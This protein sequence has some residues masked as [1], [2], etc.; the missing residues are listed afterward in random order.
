[1]NTSL[2]KPPD[3]P[4]LLAVQDP[5]ALADYLQ[6][7][8][9]QINDAVGTSTGGLAL[10]RAHSDLVDRVIRRMLAL[11]CERAG[12]GVAAE[13]VPIAVVATGGYGRRELC[14]HSDI[15]ITFIPHRDGDP[16]VDRVIKEM[17]TLVMR[18]FIDACGM[19]VG[20]A[21]RLLAD[22]G[23]LDHQTTC[24]LLD[25]R[26]IAGSDRLFIQ[27][28]N[29]FWAMLNPAD[30]LFAKL[31]ER[32]T[33][34]AKAGATP[35][36]VE[37]DLK[38]GAGGLR[39]LQTAVWVTQ[40]RHGLSA[41]RVRGD[42]V[43]DVLVKEAGVSPEE[44]DRLRQAKEFLFRVRS[45]LHVL[46]GAERDQLV[47]TRQE[48]LADLL[49][50]GGTARGADGATPPVEQFMREYY[51]HAAAVARITTDVMRR[52][53]NSRLFLGIGLDCKRRQIVPANPA[54]ACEDPLWMLWACELAQ[55]Y[56]LE[57]SDDLE[58]MIVDLVETRPV[59][60]D[61]EQAAE[62][63]TRILA[64][65]HGAYPT[66]QRMAD[67][68]ILGWLVPEVGEILNLIPYDPSH[69]Y[70]VGQH[71]LYVIRNLDA[72]RAADLGE[73]M[74]DFRQ[75]MAELPHPEQ[76]YLAALLHDAGKTT[77]ERPHSEVGEELAAEVCARLRWGAHAAANVQFL[78]RHHLTMAET[79]RLRDLNLDE[80]IRD[81]TSVVDDVD[82]LH[83]LYLLTYA[84]TS[85]VGAGV[86]TAV[87]GR[88]LRD[89]LRRAERALEGDEYEEFDEAGLTRTRRR[90]LKELSVE[91]LPAQE[92]EQHIDSMPA[93]YLL[94]TSLNEIALHV[95]FVRK[96]RQGEPVID[97][98]DERDSTFTEVTVC[99]PDDP[100]PGLLAKI[101]GV[102]YAADLDVHSAQVFT[103]VTGDER[104][105]ID[106]FYVD[107]RGRQLTPGKRKELA[108]N[109]TAVLT[110]KTTIAE[111]LAKHKRNPDI[112]GPVQRLTLRN[113]LS[114]A[115][116]VVEV[117]AEDERAML[118]RASGALSALGWGILSARV[119]HF[120][121]ANVAGFYVTGARA[122][123]EAEARRALEKLMPVAPSR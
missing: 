26:L 38:N 62:V 52:A 105:A 109:L 47:V 11:A 116:T 24:G 110:G 71:T 65:P 27:F 91:N 16:V 115:Y 32:R 82:R 30:F 3:D 76:L 104:I 64:S 81:F 2:L 103:R 69:D 75:I 28:E 100:K 55:K 73:E 89:L 50:Y 1:M 87:K 72:L 12:R 19:D 23:N 112:G 106:N 61:T 56:G 22:C 68:G 6:Q 10:A 51:G 36:V 8:R 120:K 42:R 92:V 15:D 25:A 95:G 7:Q 83:M 122:L 4:A 41:A 117:A 99:T 18:V 123:N 108:K 46:T 94:N 78:V 101:T 119:S 44:A 98:H 114:D 107:F 48:E 84:D 54:L 57:F 21:Y 13:T 96:A 34:R 113:D 80:T 33:Q 63:F 53:E 39:D 43:W 88:F 118:Y 93:T 121:G 17:F 5:E 67:L 111:L 70:T 45:G 9:A 60:H 49:G 59:I 77:D 85:A 14:P 29:D 97:F 74:R 86:W 40:A 37:P 35:R 31:D 20:Y 102:F 79:S 66:L 58:R 90:L